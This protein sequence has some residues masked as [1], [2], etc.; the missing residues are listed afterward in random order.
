MHR[1]SYCG[2]NCEKCKVYLATMA[3]D[4]KVKEEIANEWSALYKRNF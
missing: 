3:D 1:S 2:I 4:D